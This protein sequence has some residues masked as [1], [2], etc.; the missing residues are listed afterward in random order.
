MSDYLLLKA[1]GYL[2]LK[3]SG[4]LLLEEQE[5]VPEQIS[6]GGG[7]A[8]R[9]WHKAHEKHV[10]RMWQEIAQRE[11]E[12]T[13]ELS[14]AFDRAQGIVAAASGV[15]NLPVPAVV[16]EPI[17]ELAQSIPA[18]Q[19]RERDRQSSRLLK[20]ISDLHQAIQEAEEDEE[21]VWLLLAA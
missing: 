18:K 20:L 15:L 14:R 8:W 7:Y 17:L 19:T 9:E 4:R 13:D 10:K 2:L 6:V 1:G 5:P 3:Q 12:E 11:A 21:D 16:P